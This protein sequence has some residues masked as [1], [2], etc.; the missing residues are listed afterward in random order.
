MAKFSAE[1]VL[2]RLV[3]ASITGFLGVP[4]MYT[5]LVSRDA[6]PSS[7]Y[8]FLR[9]MFSG[10]APLDPTLKTAVEERF[11]LPLHNGYGLTESGPTIAQ[12]RLY[13]PLTDT[14]VGFVI[15]GVDYQIID[16]LG[17]GD[18]IGE[19][20]VRGPNIMAGY[21][22]D[23]VQTKAILSDGWLA[24]GDL[25]RINIHGALEIVGRIKE[26]IIKN[27]FNVYPPEVEAALLRLPEIIQAAVMGQA[28]TG[29][30]RI[31]A[32]VQTSPPGLALDLVWVNQQ[33][34]SSLAGYKLP[35]EIQVLDHLPAAPS[36]KILKHQL[37]DRLRQPA[38]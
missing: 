8:P 14:S 5:Q 37:A 16:S 23:A 11:G 25:A 20:Q 21:Y 17:S 10:G 38:R 7:R 18:G 32:F 1:A 6:D 13:A 22:R 29:N 24:T 12:T 30:E 15:P 4:A 26:L 36:G 19:L 31:V 3:D 2:A 34:R 27:G 28:V 35:D 33:L 9:F